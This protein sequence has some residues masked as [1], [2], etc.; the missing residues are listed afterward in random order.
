[1]YLGES[2]IRA[3]MKYADRRNAPL[4]IIQGGDEKQRG[5]IQIKDLVAG[6]KASA[7]I[8][9]NREWREER[10]GQEE[11]R[12]DQLV[13]LTVLAGTITML[14]GYCTAFAIPPPA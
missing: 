10:P 8:A 1:M 5:V 3:Q 11:V 7:A 12:E 13:E 14:N 2:G 4:A 9:D 6:K